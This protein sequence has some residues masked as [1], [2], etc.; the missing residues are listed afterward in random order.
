MH[1]IL[2]LIIALGMIGC[3][4]EVAG[5]A[6]VVGTTQVQNAEQAQKQM[7]QI[8]ERL[9]AAQHDMQRRMEAEGQ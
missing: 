4:A 5:T 8:N 2:A 3:G 9:D 1:A 7:N 6:A